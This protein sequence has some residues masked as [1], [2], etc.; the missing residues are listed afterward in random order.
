MAMSDGAPETPLRRAARICAPAAAAAV[1]VAFVASLGGDSATMALGVACGV[2]AGAATASL[3][4]PNVVLAEAPPPPIVQTPPEPPASASHEADFALFRQL[5]W[6]TFVLNDQGR[7]TFANDAAKTDIGSAVLGSHF[8]GLLRA[9]MLVDAVK[10]AMTTGEAA[11]VSFSLHRAQERH[12][13]AFVAPVDDADPEHRVVIVVADQTRVRRAEQL[14]RDF[15]ANASHELK[16]PLAAVAGFIETL[17]HSA[18]SDEAARERFL[19]IMAREAERMRRLVEDL[20]SLNR[21]ELKEHVQPRDVLALFAPLQSAVAATAAEAPPGR[22]IELPQVDDDLAVIG[23]LGELT[24][25]FVNLFSN[26][27]KYGGDKRA[28]RVALKS[29]DLRPDRIGVLVEDFGPGIAKEHLPRLTE[30]FY[31]VDAPRSREKGGTGLGLAIVKHIVARHRGEL[32]IDSALGRGSHFT[33]WLPLADQDGGAKED[34][35]RD[36]TPTRISDAPETV[37]PAASRMPS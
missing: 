30:R 13:S 5:P 33:V 25:V 18:R 14:H 37:E 32:I 11:E 17:Q 22:E 12:L 4:W 6:T 36:E 2:L 26:A 1:V 7:V 24:Q 29:D 3:L 15:V 21:I 27:Y 9:P 31:R 34:D 10:R 23:D 35:A 16:T 8:S 20:L 19:G 28:P